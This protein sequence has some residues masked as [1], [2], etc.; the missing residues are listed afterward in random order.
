[1]AQFWQI[2]LKRAAS[3]LLE[4]SSLNKETFSP[5]TPLLPAWD[6][7]DTVPRTV[8]AIS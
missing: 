4:F 6:A 7:R 1:M 2:S 3:E 8:Q 5:H